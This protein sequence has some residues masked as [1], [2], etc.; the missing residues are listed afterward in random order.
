MQRRGVGS[1]LLRRLSDRAP[2]NGIG[3][4]TARLLALNHSMLALFE[5]LGELE[6]NHSG[7]GQIEI[8]VELPCE[9]RLSLGAALRAAANGLVRLRP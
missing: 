3:L 4:F 8:D 5:K 1:E 9:P 7:D 6:V 2:Q